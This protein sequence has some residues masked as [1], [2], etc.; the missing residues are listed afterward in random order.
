[1][2]NGIGFHSARWLAERGCHVVLAGRSAE[3]LAAC[4]QQIRAACK[5][6]D[7]SAMPAEQVQLSEIVLDL[8]SLRSVEQFAAQFQALN[9]PLNILLNNA[10]VMDTP[11]SQTKDG[12][13]LQM[14]TNHVG[15]F[16]QNQRTR[17]IDLE[18]TACTT[19]RHA[20]RNQQQR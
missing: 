2:G 8:T 1:M 20:Q 17:T 18:R 16:C 3:R 12:F 6:A 13:E 14:G 11:Y 10:G 9:R 19:R 5:A 7:G 4:A 15:H